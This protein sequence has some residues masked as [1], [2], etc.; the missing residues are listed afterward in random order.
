MCLLLL[1]GCAINVHRFS[2]KTEHPN[3][4]VVTRTLVVKTLAGWPATAS[5]E[6]QRTSLGKT[7]SVGTTGIT[8][9]SSGGTNGVVEAL[10]S[11]DS[12]L[13]KIRP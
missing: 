7:F 2:E 8:E 13:G 4:D 11:L 3:G 9:D 1:C 10:K 5:I 12:I 6:K